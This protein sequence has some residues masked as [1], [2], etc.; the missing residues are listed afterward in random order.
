MIDAFSNPVFQS[1]LASVVYGTGN[2][3]LDLI[4]KNRS[5]KKRYQKAFEKAICRY[6]ADPEMV[7]NEARR[8]YD[9]Y[10]KMLQDASTREDILESNNHVYIELLDLFEKEVVKDKILYMHTLLNAVFTNE[11]KLGE[12]KDRL[13]ELSFKTEKSSKESH[14]EHMEIMKK[15]DG[16]VD[17]ITK[18]EI[19]SL[20][21]VTIQGSAADQSCIES[22]IIERKWLVDKCISAIE[23]GKLLVL[24]G[25]L[26][27]GKKTLAQLILKRKPDI[28]IA[29]NVLSSNL[30]TTIAK[31]FEDNPKQIHVIIAD[32][33]P[34]NP[35]ISTLDFSKIEQIEVP[36]LSNAEINELIATFNPTV[37]LSAFISAFSGGHP[38]LVRTLCTYFS[39]NG[40]KLDDKNFSKLL[41][42]SYDTDLT[43]SLSELL[44]RIITD[45][46]TRQLF[47]RLLLV[48]GGFSEETVCQL[49]EVAPCID[50][51]RRRLYTLTPNWVQNDSNGF[52]V[53]PLFY[54]AW[55]P[56]LSSESI[57]SCYK[58]LAEK[59]L[60][61]AHPLNE[62]DVINY[63]NYS[64]H[65]HEYD[66]AGSM[67]ITVLNKYHDANAEIPERSLLRSIWIDVLLPPKMTIDI[68]ISVRI[69]QLGLINKLS[70]E[71][72]QFLLWDLKQLV[73]SAQESQFKA[74]YYSAVTILCWQ[75]KEVAEGLRF[76]EKSRALPKEE[77]EKFILD[78]EFAN[79]TF[80]MNIWFFLLQLSTVE[81]Y[82]NWLKTFGNSKILYVQDDK[83]ICEICY[84]SI[85]RLVN[86]HLSGSSFDA[87]SMALKHIIERSEKY[88]CP[89]LTIVCISH[90]MDLY[91]LEKRYDDIQLL[92]QTNIDKYKDHVL[93]I[94]LFNG[95]MANSCYRSG[96]KT[97]D[98]FQ[99]YENAI[100]T[101][102]ANLIP[103]VQLHIKQLY[104]YI[105]TEFDLNHSVILLEEAL[106][107]AKNEEHRV[108]IFEYYQCKGELSYAYWRLGEK[109]KAVQLLS[110]CLSFVLPLTES[111]RRFS[112]TY[113]CLCN[114]L[115][116]Y[117]ALAIHNKPFPE[118]QVS[119]YHGMFTENDLCSLDS[120]YSIDRQY[121]SC[122]MMSDL[123][124]NMQMGDFA[125]E[126]AYK[127]IEACK[128]RGEVREIHYTL[129][130]LLPL[131]IAKNDFEAIRYV[132]EYSTKAKTLTYQNHP[133]VKN[134]NSDLQFVEFQIIPLL[135]EALVL[136]ICGNEEGMQIIREVLAEYN[137]TTDQ[138][139]I[140]LVREVFARESYDRNYIA[141]INDLDINNRYSVYLCAYLITAVHSEADYAF[142]LLISILPNLEKQ[143]VCLLGR[144]VLVIINH[145]VKSFWKAKILR[146]PD[147][148]INYEHLRSKG[149]DLI[150]EYEGKD[151]QANHTM[152][153]VSNHLKN[154]IKL[155]LQQEEWLDA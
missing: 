29:D 49:A 8:N 106:K 91:T 140:D 25:T 11:K 14:Q 50:E 133:E 138:E 150:D 15:F 28:R 94:I 75:E 3:I 149:L 81:D 52:K 109:K 43:R 17:L 122:Y 61:L 57:I 37:D 48:L 67:F 18:K 90:L 108:D 102:N 63:I 26:K 80:D 99:Y 89:E 101:S 62:K 120:L 38:V 71:Q 135:M 129:F 40:W 6:Y 47:N 104:S 121:I 86:H 141:K 70:K 153:I 155:N 134:E 132:M 82:D 152:L 76:Y 87:K 34:L 45:K 59:I 24:H 72:R 35:N 98:T 125:Y 113:L 148:F 126:W 69:A 97:K 5:F 84:L 12:I 131:F 9:E 23:S 119:P 118:D 13:D 146:S 117:F 33:A 100:H 41:Y 79:E 53:N 54:K 143:L 114:C 96:N 110:S 85:T 127:A 60:N 154:G 46:D 16:V 107:Y 137:A 66:D 93:A 36:L 39:N 83:L 111:E 19:Q 65:A 144:R 22:H 136:E 123:C 20:K 77:T 7:G 31:L 44:S 128:K 1:L 64:I 95:A 145:F 105:L 30:E 68:K 27:V 112:K 58:L 142:S 42:Y 130:L 88:E 103:N 147:E 10:L 115:L 32:A 2:A 55:K 56:D 92:Y 139:G 4:V 73:D 124:D 21:I 74:F 51:P 116:N 151:N 78:L